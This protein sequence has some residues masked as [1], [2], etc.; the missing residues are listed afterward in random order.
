LI[1]LHGVNDAA[2]LAF[3]NCTGSS[4]SP[5][6]TVIRGINPATAAKSTKASREKS[7]ILPRVKSDILGWDTPSLAAASFWVQ[8]RRRIS[9]A[10]ACISSERAPALAMGPSTDSPP[11][12]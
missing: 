7:S 4:H 1:G 5:E 8:P 12:S 10:K 3:S 2:S 6:I 9:A 11:D